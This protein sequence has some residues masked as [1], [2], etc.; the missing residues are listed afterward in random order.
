MLIIFLVV[1]VCL[2]V[3]QLPV[4][5][6]LVENGADLEAVTKGGETP[7]GRCQTGN[8]SSG[9]PMWMLLRLYMLGLTRN[10][11]FPGMNPCFLVQSPPFITRPAITRYRV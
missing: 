1:E 3:F 10:A 2:R 8:A 9:A 7:L 4:L 6:L 11:I 5:E